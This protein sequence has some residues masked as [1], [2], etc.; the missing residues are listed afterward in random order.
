MGNRIILIVIAFMIMVGAIFLRMSK[1]QHT[2]TSIVADQTYAQQARQLAN[3][4]AEDGIRQYK[5]DTTMFQNESPGAVKQ[6]PVVTDIQGY[7]NSEANVQITKLDDDGN[8]RLRS[9]VTFTDPSTGE[10]YSGETVIDFEGMNAY[11]V[12]IYDTY[13]IYVELWNDLYV[14]NALNEEEKMILDELGLLPET[15]NCLPSC[16]PNEDFHPGGCDHS[17]LFPVLRNAMLTNPNVHQSVCP[18]LIANGGESHEVCNI[19]ELRHLLRDRP[20]A[21]QLSQL[22]NNIRN[23]IWPSGIEHYNRLIRYY[24]VNYLPPYFHF[25]ESMVDEYEH[26]AN[27]LE[28]DLMTVTNLLA[29][30]TPPFE[31]DMADHVEKRRRALGD[32]DDHF[33]IKNW[34]ES[35]V[36]RDN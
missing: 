25:G 21:P 6:F 11:T 29:A 3:S 20:Q 8:Y 5:N 15:I 23:T 27:F 14:A 9:V 16:R 13:L 4:F 2:A 1:S 24:D 31:F 18:I 22:H 26:W 32:T 35:V 19:L 36:Q 34:T 12:Y 17:Q 7:T 33:Q 10:I 30:N 28:N